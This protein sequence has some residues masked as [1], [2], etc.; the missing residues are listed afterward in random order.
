ML[1]PSP[2][3]LVLFV[4]AG[5]FGHSIAVGVELKHRRPG[6]RHV[7]EAKNQQDYDGV[8]H[9]NDEGSLGG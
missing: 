5:G 6:E 9:I 3:F 4:P 2:D 7:W 8:A 1:P